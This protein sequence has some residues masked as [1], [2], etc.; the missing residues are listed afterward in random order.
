L[1]RSGVRASRS[2]L[3]PPYQR[4]HVSPQLLLVVPLLLCRSRGSGCSRGLLRRRDLTSGRRC[5]ADRC[6]AGLQLLPQLGQLRGDVA[7]HAIERRG[8]HVHDGGSGRRRGAG[9]ST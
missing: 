9:G 4:G 1:R 8:D 6:L 7:P 2:G 3:H 5:G